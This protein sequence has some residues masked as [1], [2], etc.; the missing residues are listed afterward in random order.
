MS[1]S[2]K[3]RLPP[4]QVLAAKGKWPLVG[5]RV[6]RND[7][8]PWCVHAQGLVENPCTWTHE[9][10]RQN[11]PW[12]QRTLDIHCV[13]RWSMLGASF[14]G[15]ALLDVLKDLSLSPQ[16]QFV[17]F[18]ARSDRSHSTSLPLADLK[19]LDPLLAFEYEGQPLTQEHG[20]PLRVVVAARYFYKSLKWLESLVFLENDHLG[21]WEG[22]SGYHNH[23][24]PW[25]EERYITSGLKRSEVRRLLQS[26]DLSGQTLLSLEAQSMQLSGLN[27]EG[28]LLRNANFQ[29]ANL[30]HCSFKHANLSNAHFQGACMKGANLEGADVEGANFCGADLRGCNFEQASLFGATFAPEP[31]APPSVKPA[32]LDASTHIPTQAWEALSDAQRMFLANNLDKGK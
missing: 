32:I 26:K 8:S 22:E 13:T 27:A 18:V 12:Q 30:A 21:Y 31:D 7:N 24:D 25:K 2:L 1:T 4:N 17:S 3:D 28:A 14:S 23:A 6:P 29:H 11:Y 5:E 20:G 10:L 9:E 16:A 15:I 19:E